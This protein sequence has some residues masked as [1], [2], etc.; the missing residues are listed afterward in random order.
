[1]K[2]IHNGLDLL[3][4][5]L[6]FGIQFTDETNGV[7]EFKGLGRHPRANGVSG[8][9]ADSK[10]HLT[11]VAAFGGGLQKCFQP[12]QMSAGDLFGAWELFQQSVD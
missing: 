7:L 12:G 4:D 9:V 3:F 10:R 8:S 1:M 11:L 2:L 6:N 5:F